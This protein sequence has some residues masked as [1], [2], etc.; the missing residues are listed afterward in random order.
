V[1]VGAPRGWPEVV[2]REVASRRGG[3]DVRG[4]LVSLTAGYNCGGAPV[5]CPNLAPLTAVVIADD[6]TRLELRASHNER[7]EELSLGKPHLFS[8]VWCAS[9]DGGAAFAALRGASIQGRT[10]GAAVG[11]WILTEPPRPTAKLE[12]WPKLP[13]AELDRKSVL[14]GG[15][16]TDRFVPKRCPPGAACKPQPPAHVTL[17]DRATSPANAL[18]L[19]TPSPMTIAMGG[20]Y[21]ASVVLCGSSTY[22]GGNEGTLVAL[23]RK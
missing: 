15:W 5:G 16:V 12:A 22:G 7:G 6:G 18:V 14:P 17:S 21:Q 23:S 9:S 13:L 11:C 10:Q 19:L 1:G 3:V 20:P 2:G 4:K 8:V